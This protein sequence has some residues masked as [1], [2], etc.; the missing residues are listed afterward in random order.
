MLGDYMVLIVA[1]A[2][3]G[4]VPLCFRIARAAAPGP[5]RAA[6]ARFAS[7]TPNF[8]LLTIA[9]L[10][11][12]TGV[13]A[14]VFG[15]TSWLSAIGSVGAA[16]VVGVMFCALAALASTPASAATVKPAAQRRDETSWR[17]AA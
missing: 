17:R 7:D 10:T 13:A 4:I 8:A 9:S 14:A 5:A 1:A 16:V 6:N 15:G 11:L 12:T 3:L 2:M